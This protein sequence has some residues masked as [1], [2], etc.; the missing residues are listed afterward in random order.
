MILEAIVD[1]TS[2]CPSLVILL[3]EPHVTSCKRFV[4]ALTAG[5]ENRICG[6]QFGQDKIVFI[7]TVVVNT[8]GSHDYDFMNY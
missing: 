2:Y 5:S 8:I 3:D 1:L 7:T 6:S 4:D